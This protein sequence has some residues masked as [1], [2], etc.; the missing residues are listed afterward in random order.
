MEASCSPCKDDK[1]GAVF[2]WPCRVVLAEDHLLFRQLVKRFLEGMDGFVVEGE[3]SDG[4]ELLELLT[5]CRPHLVIMDLTMPRLPGLEATRRVKNSYPEVKILILTMHRIPEYCQEA[6]EA[7]AN[8]YL[9]KED[10][11]TELLGAI[12][13]IL[14]GGRYI[15]PLLA[16]R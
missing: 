12:R 11:D 15:S 8:G 3:A 16:K 2:P 10:T 6:L 1:D 4:L 7:G 5:T 14:K 9:L 13:H